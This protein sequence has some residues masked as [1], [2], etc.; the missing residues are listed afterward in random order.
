MGKV[1]IA[2]NDD[3][4]ENSRQ[5]FDGCA[6]DIRNYCIGKSFDYDLLTPPNLTEAQFMDKAQDSHICYVAS[7]GRPD[8]VVN[9][10]GEE[11]VSTR[12]TNY[13]LNGKC[14][15]AVS[16]YCAQDLKDELFRIGLKLFVGYRDKYTEFPGYDEFM[17]SANCGLK[18]FIDGQNVAKMK[19]SIDAEYDRLFDVLNGKSVLAADA[20]LDNKESLVI[21]GDD[22][23]T[24]ADLI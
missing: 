22:S 19:D 11:F 20:L 5:F 24:I 4:S 13:N 14:F 6:T 18:V 10:E 8:S 12:T 9:E 7:H 15:F 1:L 3:A 16:C 21:E 2:Y 23:L 17:Q